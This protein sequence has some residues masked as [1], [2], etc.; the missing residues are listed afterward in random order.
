MW[1]YFKAILGISAWK[2]SIDDYPELR[3]LKFFSRKDINQAI[4]LLHEVH[5]RSCPFDLVGD[6]TLIVPVKAVRYFKR[7]GLEFKDTRVVPASELPKD[8]LYELRK[9]QGTF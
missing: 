6:N 5:L 2:P 4:D 9:T 3:A 8:E 7:T 1:R